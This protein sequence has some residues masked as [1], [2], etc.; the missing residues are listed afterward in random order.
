MC[1]CVRLHDMCVV[2]V[3]VSACVLVFV[4]LLA[5]VSCCFIPKLALLSDFMCLSLSVIS[6]TD[7]YSMGP[8]ILLTK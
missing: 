3:S 5:C 8:G 2:T 7:R 1:V 4:V 6:L